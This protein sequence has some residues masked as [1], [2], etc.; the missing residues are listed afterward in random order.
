MQKADAILRCMLKIIKM[1]EQVVLIEHKGRKLRIA[2]FLAAQW[3]LFDCTPYI[4]DPI[5]IKLKTW[6]HD[7]M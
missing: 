5:T 7:V 2:K 4:E 6:S 1:H 3:Q